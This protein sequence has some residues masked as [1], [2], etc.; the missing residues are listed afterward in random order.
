MTSRGSDPNT[1]RKT[2]CQLSNASCRFAAPRPFRTQWLACVARDFLTTMGEPGNWRAPGPSPTPMTAE[3]FTYLVKLATDAVE[4][5]Q[6]DAIAAFTDLWLGGNVTNQ[7]LRMNG[8]N[9]A[10]ELGYGSFRDAAAAWR[11]L[12][13]LWPR[14]Q[15]R[16][17]LALH[18]P[19]RDSACSAANGSCEPVELGD[20]ENHYAAGR[21][22]GGILVMVELAAAPTWFV[23]SP[24]RLLTASCWAWCWRPRW[25]GSEN[26]R[27]GLPPRQIQLAN[28]V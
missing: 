10:P 4:Q 9:L 15:R 16:G 6:V 18:F 27:S 13:Q 22:P 7:P 20:Y 19:D 26:L 8:D 11:S 3:Q 23:R 2:S 28:A 14:V 12:Q 5:E 24:P 25:R 1:A 17:S 21:R